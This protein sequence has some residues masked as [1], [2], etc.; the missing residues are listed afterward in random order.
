MCE[1]ARAI[2]VGLGRR[3]GLRSLSRHPRR[4]GQRQ[5][6]S[7]RN[8][9]TA[10]P[11]HRSPPRFTFSTQAELKNPVKPIKSFQRLSNGKAA[12]VSPPYLR[13]NVEWEP[14]FCSR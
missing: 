7:Q 8:H 1:K 5:P 13:R 2:E 6:N 14:H 12:V 11:T 9:H 10:Y 3:R 4:E